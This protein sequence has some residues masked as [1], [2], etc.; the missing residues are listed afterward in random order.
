[1]GIS[2]DDIKLDPTDRKALTP[3]IKTALRRLRV[4]LGHPT[5]D[6]LTRAWLQ[7]EALAWHKW[8]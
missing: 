6:D 4:N 2:L 8:Q 3:G 5:N 1:M 7:E